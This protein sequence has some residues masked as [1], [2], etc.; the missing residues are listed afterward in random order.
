MDIKITTHRLPKGSHK[1]RQMQHN[2][3]TGR[4]K[5]QRIRTY[6]NKIDARKKHLEA[7]P[8]D[9]QAIENIRKAQIK[10]DLG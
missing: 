2:L 6:V 1:G 7:H 5:K 3:A 8:N 4:Y 9:V 10:N